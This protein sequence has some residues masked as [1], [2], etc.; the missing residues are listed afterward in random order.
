VLAIWGHT[1]AQ[2]PDQAF[3]CL[4]GFRALCLGR[5]RVSN[6][7]SGWNGGGVWDRLHLGVPGTA[8]GEGHALMSWSLSHQGKL[9]PREAVS[10]QSGHGELALCP[11]SVLVISSPT[12]WNVTPLLQ[13]HMALVTRTRPSWV[14]SLT[15]LTPPSLPP[16]LTHSFPCWFRNSHLPVS[17]AQLH[18]LQ[19]PR[20]GVQRSCTSLAQEPSV[21]T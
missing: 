5:E 13:P 1:E 6:L 16:S 12:F 17:G 20:G 8:G 11:M 7:W 2:D 14:G 3:H 4:R 15:L 18:S 19:P 10:R 9:R 21:P